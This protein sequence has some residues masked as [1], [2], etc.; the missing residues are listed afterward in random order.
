MPGLRNRKRRQIHPS[1]ERY[2][3]F[4]RAVF[5]GETL[6]SAARTAGYCGTQ[7]RLY[8]LSNKL[9][10]RA[11]VS[12]ELEHLRKLADQ[13][14]V[15]S[16][17]DLGLYLTAVVLA[18]PTVLIRQK[19]NKHGEAAGAEVDLEAVR[20][21]GAQRLIQR[22]TLRPDGSLTIETPGKLEAAALLAKM[23]GYLAPERREVDLSEKAADLIAR[24]L[25]TLPDDQFD[26]LAQRILTPQPA[27][28]EKPPETPP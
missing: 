3:A 1:L 19:W 10:N 12:S 21:L 13:R 6:C 4:A 27:L 18:D 11:E 8:A 15:L 26:K 5:A 14:A 28:P 9:L 16:A 7:T 24:H 25:Q 20:T 23:R 17:D 22:V 2:R